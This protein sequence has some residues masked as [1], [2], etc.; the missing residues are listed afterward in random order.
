MPRRRSGGRS[1]TARSTFS[2][3]TTVLSRSEYPVSCT[4]RATVSRAGICIVGNSRRRRGSLRDGADGGAGRDVRIVCGYEQRRG[5][6]NER[7]LGGGGVVGAGEDRRSPHLFRAGRTL[8][9]G[10]S[11]GRQDS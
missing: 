3:R 6:G 8:A 10:N 2:I 7:D 5:K 11:V 9:A 4:S 1:P